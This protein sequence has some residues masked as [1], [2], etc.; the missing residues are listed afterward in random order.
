MLLLLLF[1]IFRLVFLVCGIFIC[2]SCFI[3]GIIWLRIVGWMVRLGL[4]ML[5]LL[6][7][8][9]MLLFVFNLMK[10]RL[11]LGVMIFWFMFMILRWVSFVL[12][13][14]VMKVVF[15]CCSMRVIYWCWV[16][17]IDWFVFGILRRVFV[18]RFF[19]V[20]LVLCVVCKFW[21]L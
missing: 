18:F 19:M 2:L 9:V 4:S 13:L 10:I 17:W 6:F 14:K 15:G 3:G 20:I 1:W 7:I 5:F 12:S 8:Y 21:C 11:L 16:V